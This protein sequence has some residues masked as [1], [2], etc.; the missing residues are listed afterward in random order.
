MEDIEVV[1]NGNIHNHSII[2]LNGLT[3]GVHRDPN[4][5][6]RSF[7]QLRRKGLIDKFVSISEKN[8]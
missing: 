3:V 8:G 6:M 2:F 1:G 5:F 7:R 4:H